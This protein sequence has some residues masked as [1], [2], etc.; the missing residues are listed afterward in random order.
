MH[1]LI[2]NQAE[3]VASWWLCQRQRFDKASRPA[4]DAVFLMIVWNLWKH[5]NAIVFHRRSSTDLLSLY[6]DTVGE[7]HDW[8]Q[9]RYNPL[10]E[11]SLVWSQSV[12]VS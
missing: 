3:D 4:V 7:A 8:V 6:A 10:A 11:I 12:P 9:A 1:S 2:P 5:R